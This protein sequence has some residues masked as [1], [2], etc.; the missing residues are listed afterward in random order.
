[1]AVEEVFYCTTSNG[2]YSLNI[3]DLTQTRKPPY[4]NL[5]TPTNTVISDSH[6]DALLFT[7][8]F[9]FYNGNIKPTAEN[10]NIIDTYKER[11]INDV[12]W[13]E[14]FEKEYDMNSMYDVSS[15]ETCNL[16]STNPM[17]TCATLKQSELA[18]MVDS[19]AELINRNSDD[20]ARLRY[21][22]DDTWRGSMLE[23]LETVMWE[24]EALLG[25]KRRTAAPYFYKGKELGI[26]TWT[27]ERDI[28]GK[29]KVPKAKSRGKQLQKI[30]A[31]LANAATITDEQLKDLIVE[32]GA[33]AGSAEEPVGTWDVPFGGRADRDGFSLRL[34]RFL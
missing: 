2:V 31:A 15:R 24:Y 29:Q 9:A 25:F 20:Y 5:V 16:F 28:S 23:R 6:F 30:K 10:R 22:K 8:M 4:A 12:F 27:Y 1:M 32:V 34:Q 26:N 13:S 33:E 21:A 17:P 11:G 14:Q 18:S 19:Y 7:A 3:W